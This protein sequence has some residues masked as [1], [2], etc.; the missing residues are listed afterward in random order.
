VAGEVAKRFDGVPD[1]ERI[2]YIKSAPDVEYGVV[3]RLIDALRERGITM[4]GLVAEKP[5]PEADSDR[6]RE[7][8]EP[9]AA[10]APDVA[11]VVVE[12]TPD[13]C[14]NVT[15]AVEGRKVSARLLTSRLRDRLSRAAS[16]SVIILAPKSVA[17]AQV[18]RVIDSA[19]NAGA[20]DIGLQVNYVE[21]THR[22]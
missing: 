20:T 13:G 5:K 4:I 14:G 3:V 22:P 10:P 21:P 12:V 8:G 1:K 16:K 6:G 15:Y 18:V 2:V 17:Y 9:G 19:K 7:P 11:G